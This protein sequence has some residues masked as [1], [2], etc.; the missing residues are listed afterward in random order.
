MRGISKQK[1]DENALRYRKIYDKWLEEDCTLEKLGEEYDLTKQ[2]MWQII[3]R[4]K[5]GKGDY[6]YG[7]KIARDK[8]SEFYSTYG[9]KK[10]AGLAFTDWLESNEVRIINN[11][12][13]VAPHTGWDMF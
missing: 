6:Y 2:R 13:K 1:A 12:K 8:W 3:T 7:V 11:N 10:Q 5:L 9:D 4:C